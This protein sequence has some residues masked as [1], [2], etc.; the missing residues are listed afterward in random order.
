MNLALI[1]DWLNQLGGAEDV[2]GGPVGLFPD[3]PLDETI[4]ETLRAGRA[5]D[6]RGRADSG[7]CGGDALHG[8][9]S[10]RLRNRPHTAESYALRRGLG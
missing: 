2:L 10:W 1:H 7:T 5:G 3:A 4:D 6:G 8:G 9:L